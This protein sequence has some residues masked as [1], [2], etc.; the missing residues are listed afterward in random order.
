MHPTKEYTDCK[1]Q[2]TLQGDVSF[3]DL[4]N[5]KLYRPTFNLEKSST[6]ILK[7]NVKFNIFAWLVM[8]GNVFDE[9]RALPAESVFA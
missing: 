3:Q 2:W 4:E 5:G 8:K 9:D 7:L 1:A 6:P